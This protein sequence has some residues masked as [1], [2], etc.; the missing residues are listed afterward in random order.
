MGTNCPAGYWD[1]S[2]C[3]PFPSPSSAGPRSHSHTTPEMGE[4]W[5]SAAD[6]LVFD[7]I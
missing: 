2:P 5:G 1:G 3:F 7:I 4:E 6:W